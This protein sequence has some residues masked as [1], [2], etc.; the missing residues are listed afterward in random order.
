MTR[1]VAGI[2]AGT[3]GTNGCAIFDAG[4]DWDK[5]GNLITQTFSSRYAESYD[6]DGLCRL[7]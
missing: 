5:T 4:Y 7:T 3:V 2:C 1:A 6:C